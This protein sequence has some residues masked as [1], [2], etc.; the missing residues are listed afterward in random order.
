MRDT[1]EERL[2]EEPW[3]APF[4][5]PGDMD[6]DAARARYREGQRTVTR[7]RARLIAGGVRTTSYGP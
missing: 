5:E 1:D 4:T 6:L 2:D 3:L 7:V